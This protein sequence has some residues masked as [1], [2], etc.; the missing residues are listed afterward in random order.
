MIASFHDAVA[1]FL[2][3]FCEGALFWRFRDWDFRDV[4]SLKSSYGI[5][6]LQLRSQN[7]VEYGTFAA[8]ESASGAGRRLTPAETSEKNVSNRVDPCEVEPKIDVAI[9][10]V[11]RNAP[12][13]ALSFRSRDFENFD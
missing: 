2:A 8:R 11:G 3:H 1:L 12:S 10:V 9:H 4:E 7:H 13:S 5:S 6:R